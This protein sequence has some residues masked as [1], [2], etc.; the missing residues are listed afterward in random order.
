MCVGLP[1]ESPRPRFPLDAVLFENGYPSDA[2][3]LRHIEQYDALYRQ[4][5]L[6]RSGSAAD[7]STMMARK[8][9]KASRIEVGPYYRSKGAN[10]S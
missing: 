9:T 6:E 3:V 4:Y 7:W 10:L 2:K 8:Y 1:A 5:M